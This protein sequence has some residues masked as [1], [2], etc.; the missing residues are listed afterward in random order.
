M[1]KHIELFNAFIAEQKAFFEQKLAT[2]F[3]QHWDD[4]FWTSGIKGTGWLRGNGKQV[5][6]FDEIKRFKGIAGK[7]AIDDKHY[8]DFMKAMLVLVNRKRSHSISPSAAMATLMILKRWYD[9]LV[10]VTG[11]THPIYLTTEV[12]IRAMETFSAASKPGDPNTANYKSRCVNLQQLVNHH[13]FTLVTLNY[14]SDSKFTNKTNLTRKAWETM[15]LKHYETLEDDS[16]SEAEELIIIKGFLNIVVLINRVEADSEKIA[17]NCLLL[18]VVTGFRSVEAF[19][20]R[21]DALIKRQIDDPAIR[22]RVKAKGLPDYFLGIRYI[23]VRGAG[24]RTHWV[25][26]LAVHLVESIFKAVKMLTAPMRAH[27]SYLRAKGFSDF[28]PQQIVELPGEQ[29]ELDDVIEFVALTS[30]GFRGCAGMRDKAS[31]A[32][33][34]RGILPCFVKAEHLYN[35]KSICFTKNDINRLIQKEF[36][37][38]DNTLPCTHA[39]AE[40][41]KKYTVNYEDLLFLH[42]KNSLSLKRSLAFITNPVP[43]DNRLLNKFLGNLDREQSIFSKYHLLEE[44]GQPTQLRTISPGIISTHFWLLPRCLTICRPC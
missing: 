40:Y 18:L 38:R 19:N 39:W 33:Q 26:P 12:I 24:E 1:R 32:L 36:G 30:S 13:A 21:Q 5:L 9:A 7:Q 42:Y 23:G 6:R 16:G 14:T 15:A 37:S 43:L 22:K 44:D 17:L 3:I 4:A 31:K 29:I 35:S 27:L 34:K 25:E 11:Q 2:E 20:L 8:I 41:G 10:K 28:L